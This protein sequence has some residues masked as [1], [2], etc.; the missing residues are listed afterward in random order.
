MKG[1]TRAKVIVALVVVAILAIALVARIWL[2]G[3]LGPWSLL[4][5]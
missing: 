4:V 2:W 1:E 5:K 3:Q